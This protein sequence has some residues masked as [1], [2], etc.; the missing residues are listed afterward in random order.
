MEPSIRKTR[1]MLPDLQAE[2]NE[3]ECGHGEGHGPRQGDTA[4]CRAG[5]T[6]TA[7][8]LPVL[9][10][11]ASLWTDAGVRSWRAHTPVLTAV[12]H[13][14]AQ[15]RG[16]QHTQS[17]RTRTHAHAHTQQLRTLLLQLTHA[18]TSSRPGAAGTLSCSRRRRNLERPRTP[19]GSRVSPQSTGQWLESTHT[20][21]H[22]H[23]RTHT[24]THTRTHAQHCLS[25]T[26]LLAWSSKVCL[27]V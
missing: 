9:L 3:S 17:A 12:F 19:A 16:C 22:A 15:V 5:R 14:G 4:S 7:A 25:L 1:S 8:A 18:C 11:R 26:F 27:R 10:Q 2:E 23:A 20:H 6:L 13:R 21:T 24:H